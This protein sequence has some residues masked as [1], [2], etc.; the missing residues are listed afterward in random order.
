[1]N[2]YQMYLDQFQ[3]N[4]RAISTA[5]MEAAF[6]N[7]SSIARWVY[8]IR[9]T[10]HF[11]PY[12]ECPVLTPPWETCWMEYTF[13][14]LWIQPSGEITRSGVA[15]RLGAVAVFGVPL[16]D[17]KL[18]LER[19][20]IKKSADFHIEHRTRDHLLD[21]TKPVAVYL[22][23]NRDRDSQRWLSQGYYPSRILELQIFISA[24][25]REV[26]WCGTTMAYLDNRG[27]MMRGCSAL[28]D[29]HDG[30]EGTRSDAL[31]S[32]LTM[33]ALFALSLL[34]CR[35]VKVIDNPLP[36]KV[37]AARLKNQREV[38]EYKTLK[39][40]P[41]KQRIKRLRKETDES[42][43]TVAQ[44]IHDRR[45]HFKDYREGKGLFGKIKGIWWWDD[46]VMGDID[47]GIIDKDYKIKV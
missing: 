2:L 33:P 17:G 46:W 36:P 13:P 45:G 39:I 27:R 42:K 3:N 21:T 10:G 41:M 32:A 7:I 35:N 37:R 28:I 9:G 16:E 34:H 15:G 1:M 14:G 22:E 43:L 38:I 44:P 26:V 4:R 47:A 12:T 19:D 24:P 18:A 23:P 5:F 30:A 40:E 6:I 20:A 31:A 8:E 25:G 11:E 29:E